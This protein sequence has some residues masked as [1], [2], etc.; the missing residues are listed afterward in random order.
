MER[1]ADLYAANCCNLFH[2]PLFYYFRAPM[3][4]LPHESTVEHDAVIQEYNYPG[5]L[6][7]QTSVREESEIIYKSFCLK[8][9]AIMTSA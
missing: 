2:Y 8:I 4:L 9:L 7:R 5:K 3:S 1:Y 6:I